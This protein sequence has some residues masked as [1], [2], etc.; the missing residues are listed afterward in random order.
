MITRGKKNSS[1]GFNTFPEGGE[2]VGTRAGKKHS[3]RTIAI[4]VQVLA[5]TSCDKVDAGCVASR[6]AT[7]VHGGR[8]GCAGWCG[9]SS[10]PG[11]R[12]DVQ[13]FIPVRHA[14]LQC[15]HSG[16]SRPPWRSVPPWRSPRDH[17][18]KGR[19]SQGLCLIWSKKRVFRNAEHVL[20]GGRTHYQLLF[21]IDIRGGGGGGV[22]D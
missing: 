12:A 1:F 7:D 4:L 9:R 21:G 15:R 10:A 3:S 11:T 6:S 19:E 8:C 17:A 22:T 18:A 20:R 14:P 5:C 13:K 2:K 16:D